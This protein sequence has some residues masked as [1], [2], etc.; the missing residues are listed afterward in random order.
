MEEVEQFDSISPEDLAEGAVLWSWPLQFQSHDPMNILELPEN[1]PRYVL[2][3]YELKHQDG[4][5]SYPL[6]L[7]NWAPMSS[8]IGVLTLHAS[9]LL[10]FQNTV[11][12]PFTLSMYCWL[13]PLTQG[14]CFEGTHLYRYLTFN[15]VTHA[16][17][18]C[19]DHWNPRRRGIFD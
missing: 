13:L 5:K 10:N 19:P 16:Y 11:W 17:R 7:V 15:D 3:S 4:R 6:V 2:L 12:K 9:A 18:C 8:E 1:S 14:G